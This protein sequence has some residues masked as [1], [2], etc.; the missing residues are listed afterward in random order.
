MRRWVL[1]L[2]G[3]GA[4]AACGG[5]TVLEDT[6]PGVPPKKDAGSSTTLVDGE[7]ADNW[8]VVG[9]GCAV[10]LDVRMCTPKCTQF[11]CCESLYDG[12]GSPLGVGMCWIDRPT[13]QPCNVGCAACV[14]K[15]PGVDICVPEYLCTG[16]RSLSGAIRA[17]NR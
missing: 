12:K 6:I 4:W 8:T 16:F 7:V 17:S 14:H 10:V 11:D 9:P 13:M 3:M 5:R 15:M 2:L 1:L